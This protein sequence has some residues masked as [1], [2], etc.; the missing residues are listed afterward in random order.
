MAFLSEFRCEICC[1]LS[2]NP[3]RWLVIRN[4][5]SQLSALRWDEPRLQSQDDVQQPLYQS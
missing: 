1:T 3:V 2:Q 5:A 4:G